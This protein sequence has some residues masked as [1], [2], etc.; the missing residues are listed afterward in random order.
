MKL[1]LDK[2]GYVSGDMLAA[3]LLATGIVSKQEFEEELRKLNLGEEYRLEYGEVENEGEGGYHFKVSLESRETVSQ[4]TEEPPEEEKANSIE[5]RDTIDRTRYK[6]GHG[7]WKNA[8]GTESRSYLRLKNRLRYDVKPQIDITREENK[9]KI[10]RGTLTEREKY[11]AQRFRSGRRYR[12]EFLDREEP[13]SRLRQEGKRQVEPTLPIIPV[14][15]PFAELKE[16]ILQSE[17]QEIVKQKSLEVFELIAD[18][19][20]DKLQIPKDEVVIYEVVEVV[21]TVILLN[22]LEIE[23]IYIDEII[24]LAIEVESEEEF[25]TFTPMTILESLSDKKEKESGK[26]FLT[27]GGIGVLNVYPSIFERPSNMKVKAMGTACKQE[28][29]SF[30]NSLRAILF[31]E[32]ELKP[33]ELELA[34][35]EVEGNGFED[36]MKSEGFMIKDIMEVECYIRDMN[37]E[38]LDYLVTKLESFVLEFSLSPVIVKTSK[39]AYRLKV[40]CCEKDLLDSI[41]QIILHTNAIEIYTKKAKRYSL[42][43]Q[44]E[45]FKTELGEV[46]VK[47]KIVR[48]EVVNMKLDH[49]DVITISEKNG[50]KPQEVRQIFWR[51][52]LK[53]W[54]NNY[55]H[56]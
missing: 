55:K 9:S 36:K 33:E 39:M 53:N 19:R 8:Y 42:E 27:L 47:K 23:E 3:S 34:L 45:T 21:A 51:E 25:I 31:E 29:P 38:E 24:P 43:I 50:I 54:K 20:S 52:I 4:K 30:E 46:K 35:E 15:K 40:F 44:E 18:V 16:I 56:N 49:K 32:A 12:N 37:S 1:Y 26:E 5:Q 6:T 2:V 14:S 11:I 22:K 41:R 28:N 7:K 48:G 17:L 10:N 13:E